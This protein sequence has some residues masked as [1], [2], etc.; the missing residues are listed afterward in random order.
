VP[1]DYADAYFWLAL[2]A[3]EKVNGGVKKEDIKGWRDDA[4]SHLT[5][6]ELAQVQERVRKWIDEHSSR[7]TPSIKQ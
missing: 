5:P 3:S 4:A 1:R 6:T 7:A 2:A